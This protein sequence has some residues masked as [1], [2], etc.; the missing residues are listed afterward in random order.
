MGKLSP[1]ELLI[2]RMRFVCFRICLLC[3]KVDSVVPSVSKCT[4]IQFTTPE[5]CKQDAVLHGIPQKL[6]YE[7]FTVFGYQSNDSAEDS[8]S[9]E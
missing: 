4:M 9:V 8:K 6:Q 3:C 2:L 7:D 5:I 1:F